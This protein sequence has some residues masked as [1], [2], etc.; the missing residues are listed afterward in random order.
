MQKNAEEYKKTPGKSHALKN[1]ILLSLFSF[2]SS[3]NIS[4]DFLE[5]SLAAS[6]ISSS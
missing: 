5:R 6:T 3:L 2:L 4:D 1:V